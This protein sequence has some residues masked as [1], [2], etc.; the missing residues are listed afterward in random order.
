MKFI[1]K[2]LS[3]MALAACLSLSAKVSA[4]E[5]KKDAHPHKTSMENIRSQKVAYFTDKLA[6]TPEES[7]KFWPVYNMRERI[8]NKARMKT[9]RAMKTLC[10][11]TES[12]SATDAEVK[13]LADDVF[14][15]MQKEGELS[16][17][18]YEEYLK[19]LPVKKAVKVRIIEDQFM[20]HLIGKLRKPKQEK[21]KKTARME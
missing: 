6:L 11:A 16:K 14:D 8:S 20:R 12:E 21:D 5:N 1:I 4:Q 17:E 3:V 7:E 9:R 2:T 18:S 10:E 13:K 15:S 19:V